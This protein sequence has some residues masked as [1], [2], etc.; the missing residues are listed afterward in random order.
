M[1][2]QPLFSIPDKLIQT[3]RLAQHLV[4]LTGAGISAESG[5]PTFREAQTGLWAQYDPQ[6]LATPQAFRRNPKLVWEW[7]A[8]RRN[9][10]TNVEP[11]PGHY[12]LAQL[13]QYVPKVTLITQN[14]DGLHQ[15]AGSSHPIELHG[16]ITRTKCFDEDKVITTWEETDM[17]PPHCPHC[18]SYLRPDVVWFGE[19]LPYQSL[20]DALQAA[21]SCDVFF[22][23]GT[24]AV[25][26][27][28]ASLPI[29]AAQAGATTVEINP[30][31]TPLTSMMTYVLA[32]PSGEVLPA[33]LTAVWGTRSTEVP[34]P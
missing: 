19:N 34:H 24:S 4:I 21:R 5:V 1:N 31:P 30:Q 10:V 2:K 29:E 11:N 28:A 17:I 7:Y 3:L 20:R 13:E 23:I 27:P 32:A 8:W 25:V 12:A 9:L 6:E 22:S 16:N 26:Q 15:R 14:I 33:L 18:G